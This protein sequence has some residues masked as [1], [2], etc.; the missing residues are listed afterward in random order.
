LRFI[1]ENYP[2]IVA[3]AANSLSNIDN[4]VVL[5]GAEGMEDM[6][7]KAMTR[8]G[9]GLGLAQK[10]MTSIRTDKPAN[11]GKHPRL[12]LDE[13]GDTPAYAAPANGKLDPAA[14]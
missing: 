11:E 6:L 5:N 3:A 13:L 12:P 1:A 8:G 9:A 7:A 2:A 14:V 4:L 10:L